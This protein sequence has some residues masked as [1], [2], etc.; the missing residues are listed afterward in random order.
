MSTYY[1]ILKC[2]FMNKNKFKIGRQFNKKG[3]S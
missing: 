3:Y 1:K 2:M